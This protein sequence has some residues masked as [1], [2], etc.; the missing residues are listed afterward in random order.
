MKKITLSLTLLT[1]L[2]LFQNVSSTNGDIESLQQA[3]EEGDIAA[4][5]QLG[6]IYYT[7]Q[8]VPHDLKEAAKWYRKVAEQGF[9]TAQHNL[10]IMY[11]RGEGVPQD[12]EIAFGWYRKAAEQGDS[13][14]QNNLGN[15]Y[16]KGQGIPKND[17]EAVKWYRKA[18]EQGYAVAQ[19][20]LGV[21]YNR[22][23]GIFKD[24]NQA[25]K[26][27][28]KAADQGYVEA[29]RELGYFQETPV[30]VADNQLIT[31]PVNAPSETQAPLSLNTE[32]SPE[33]TTK[34]HL[35]IEP[36]TEPVPTIPLFNNNPQ[37]IKPV[38]KQTEKFA[39]IEPIETS[40]P[41]I[42]STQSFN[43]NPQPTIIEPIENSAEKAVKKTIE[44]S[45]PP[46]IA[47]TP[48]FN[49]NPQPTIIEPI[50]NSAE[51]AVKKTIETSMPPT[52]AST[53]SYNNNPQPTIIEPVENSTE[54]AVTKNI[55]TSM[56]PAIASTQ[57]FNNNPQPTII[58]PV[59]KR[60]G[61]SAK[62]ESIEEARKRQSIKNTL[63]LIND[64]KPLPLP[65]TPQLE[66]SKYTIALSY[67]RKQDKPFMTQLANYLREKGYKVDR[68]GRSYTQKVYRSQWDI[69][70]YYDRKSAEELKENI[71]AF[72]QS[73]EG[74]NKAEIRVRDFS[75]LLKRQQ[76]IKRGR[77]EVWILNPS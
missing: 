28:R 1:L 38:E 76:K 27:Y 65:E 64:S 51:K 66:L 55:E 36:V 30:T 44:T 6:T 21:A 29:Q 26:W 60:T 23:E 74:I 19:Y 13:R 15:L 63:A 54:K 53:P 8:D 45:M 72:L 47:S 46:A 58:E 41:A 73:I 59:E 71:T 9:A 3:A 39:V 69:R 18:A 75:Y 67:A 49:N 14:S 50:E 52:I 17:K 22:G 4:Q 31:S 16:R 34:E 77:I 5:F 35:A 62:K 10:G 57:S 7:G 40:I 32:T 48:S 61:S 20:N 24:K 11:S 56:P 70:Y 42:T 12:H 43:N 2:V 68:I 37:P 25:I 33:V